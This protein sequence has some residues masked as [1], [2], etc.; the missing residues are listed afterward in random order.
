[1]SEFQLF[2]DYPLLAHN[3]FGFDVHAKHAV[4]LT[5]EAQIPALARDARLSGMRQLVLG[6]GS[7][8]VLTRNF[9]GDRKSV[10]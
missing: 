10:V 7:N 9:D 6:G 8:V 3:T 1:M 2:S 4:R 5:E